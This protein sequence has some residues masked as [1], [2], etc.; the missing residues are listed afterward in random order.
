MGS[1]LVSKTHRNVGHILGHPD[2]AVIGCSSGLDTSVLIIHVAYFL[3][4][5]FL[6]AINWKDTKVDSKT[7]LFTSFCYVCCV[8]EMRT[9]LVKDKFFVG[10]EV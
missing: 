3:F 9:F 7:V 1:F 8:Q 10:L 4:F 6:L 2:E 5:I